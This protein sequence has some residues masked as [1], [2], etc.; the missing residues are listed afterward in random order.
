MYTNYKFQHLDITLAKNCDERDIFTI[1]KKLRPEW[2]LSDVKIER[3]PGGF[4]NHAFS[5][6]HNNDL[7]KKD[8]GLFIRVNGVNRE[9]LETIFN[10]KDYEI[11]CIQIMNNNKIGAPLLATFNN[12]L[13]QKFMKGKVVTL[14]QLENPELVRKVAKILAEIHV[15]PVPDYLPKTWQVKE[16]ALRCLNDLAK[17]PNLE[18]RYCQGA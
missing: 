15:V 12:G 14:E 8:D 13:V 2:K 7:K 18:P 9:A 5:C 3:I 6:L 10:M 17:D 1:V 4:H 11:P 16:A